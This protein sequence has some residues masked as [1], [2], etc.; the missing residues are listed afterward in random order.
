MKR[1]LPM[2]WSAALALTMAPPSV[3]AQ[4]ASPPARDADRSRD[5]PAVSRAGLEN[6]RPFTD[7]KVAPWKQANDLVA[8]IGGWRAYAKEAQETSGDSP[9]PAAAQSPVSGA[10]KNRT[11]P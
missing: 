2:A 10:T 6:Y 9:A 3:W 4:P 7:E 8:K 1:S 5:A 11:Q